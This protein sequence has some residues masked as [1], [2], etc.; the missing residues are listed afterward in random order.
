MWFLF[1]QLK[2][3]N[4]GGICFDRKMQFDQTMEII[5]SEKNDEF[6]LNMS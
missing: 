5:K 4:F 2:K 3:E 6:D 1:L